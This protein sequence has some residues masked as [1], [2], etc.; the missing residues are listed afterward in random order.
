MRPSPP[1]HHATPASPQPGVVLGYDWLMPLLSPAEKELFAGNIAN[2]TLKKTRANFDQGLWWTEDIYNWNL[3][4]HGAPDALPPRPAPPGRAQCVC[5]GV[6]LT[7]F[8]PRPA[9]KPARLRLR[10]PWET[11]ARM[12]TRWP[13]MSFRAPWRASP[14]PSLRGAPTASGPKAASELIP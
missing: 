7:P 11:S 12:C 1:A 2:R 8:L 13:T 10:L 14:M 9:T 5:C 3:V 4:S 6:L